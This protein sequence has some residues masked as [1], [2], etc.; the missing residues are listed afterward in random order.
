M[1]QTPDALTNIEIAEVFERIANLMEI[2]GELVFKV[3]AY[4][5][6]AESLRDLPEEAA[7]LDARGEL[8][9]VPGIGKAITEKIQELLSTGKLEFLNRLEEEVPPSL[10]D[11]LRV[12]GV[13]PKKVALFWKELGLLTLTDLEAAAKAGKIA[14]LPGMG[15]K[16]EAN[17]L[18]GIAGL[19]ARGSRM[20]L[21]KAYTAGQRW[22]AWLREF[23]GVQRAEAAGS[24][25]RFKETVGDLDLV[26]ACA[27]SPALMAAFT[28][29]PNVVR[30]LGQ[31]ENKSSVELHDGL[32]IQLWAQPPESFGALWMYATGSKDHNVRLRELAQRRKLSLSER[33]LTDEAGNLLRYPTEEEVYT[34]LGLDWVPPEL[35]EDRGEIDAALNHRLPRLIETSDLRAEL[36][37]HSTWSDGLLS[38]ED[39][40]LAAIQRGHKVLAVTDHSSYLGITRGMKPEDLPRQRAEIEAARKRLGDR[41]LILHGAEVDIRADG[42]LD[43]PDEALAQLDIVIASLH[44]SLRQPREQITARLLNAIH[45]PHV[46]II[47]HP[48]GRLL[49]DRAGADLDWQAVFQAVQECGTSLEINAA[50]QRLDTDDIHTRHAVSLGIP[51][52]INTD[53]HSAADLDQAFYGVSVARRAGLEKDAVINTWESERIMAWLKSH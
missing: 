46:D 17:I 10:L 19:A 9:N 11:L 39:M 41:I 3:R 42:V 34:A 26:V 49:P 31:G 14:T 38:I 7:A 18:A 40:A 5:R 43:Y 30:V 53:A 21:G 16:T 47:A 36:H 15:A 52:T 1:P 33:G 28:S 23:P 37:S 29:H 44:A 48:T 2:K 22:L 24:L 12:S 6:A 35:R 25:R 51:I 8:P 32:R 27:D 45:N 4:Q 50:P 13:G 20:S